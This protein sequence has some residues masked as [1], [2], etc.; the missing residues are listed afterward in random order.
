[1][2]HAG[3]AHGGHPADGAAGMVDCHEQRRGAAKATGSREMKRTAPNPMAT[4]DEV[5]DVC[6]ALRLHH[7][8]RAGR[9]DELLQRGLRHPLLR[10]R[11]R[12][13]ACR[14]SSSCRRASSTPLG[15]T[16]S[17]LDNGVEA[18]RALSGGNITSLFEVEDGVRTCDDCWSVL[19]PFRGCAMVK[20]TSPR[21][22]GV[23]SH[24]R[25]HGHARRASRRFRRTR[26]I[27][28][29]GAIIRFPI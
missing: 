20:S 8:R 6:R 21:H 10:R 28:W 1:M 24:D 18:A 25:Q 23:L 7:A 13:R 9:G 4:I 14:S 11:S 2:R 16:R 26:S 27:C 22:G 29:S 12:R 15:M 5:I 3:D 17:I 19:P